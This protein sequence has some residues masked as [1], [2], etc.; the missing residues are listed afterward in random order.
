MGLHGEFLKCQ[1]LCGT[2]IWDFIP[3]RMETLRRAPVW[4]DKQATCQE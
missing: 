1:S 2:H 3:G 4:F